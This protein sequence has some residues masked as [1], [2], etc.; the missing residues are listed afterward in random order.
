LKQLLR[1]DTDS[2]LAGNHHLVTDRS[3]YAH[4]I[5]VHMKDGKVEFDDDND[6]IHYWIFPEEGYNETM[7]ETD[8]L[9]YCCSRKQFIQAD[10][11]QW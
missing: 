8:F 11:M 4:I 5:S 10:P 3:Q 1:P 9:I 7:E 2:R 6:Y